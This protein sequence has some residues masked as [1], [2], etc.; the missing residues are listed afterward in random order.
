MPRGIRPAGSVPIN[1]KKGDSLVCMVVECGR[2]ALYRSSQCCRGYCGLH[3]ELA[4]VALFS[5]LT[6]DY[7]QRFDGIGSAKPSLDYYDNLDAH[8][9]G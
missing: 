1:R 7:Y 3:K 4:S 2:P 9:E 5:D 8:D 6:A